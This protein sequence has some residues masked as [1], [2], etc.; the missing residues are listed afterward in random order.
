MSYETFYGLKEPAFSNALDSRFYFESRQHSEALVR[1]LHTVETMKGLT[2]VLG[3]I[4]TG[5]TTLAR[6]ALEMM[7]RDPQYEPS[8][9]V[10]L[11]SDITAEWLLKKIAHHLGVENPADSKDQIVHQLTERILR[12][13]E[14]GR[15]AVV[16]IDE[17]NMIQKKGIFE[18]FRGLLNLEVPGRKLIS[19]VFLGLPELEKNLAL[20]PPLLQRV[21]MKIVLQSLSHG[22][23]QQ[24]IRHRLAVAGRAGDIFTENAFQKI[25][26]YSKGIP[27][28]INTLCDN[29]MLEGYLLKR[30]WIDADIIEQVVLDLGLT[31]SY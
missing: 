19:F 1:M 11:H 14:E 5:K 17:A 6:K 4:G 28:L 15:K 27:R 30:D 18:E 8:L 23:T 21:A 25:F 3:D 12:I 9:L 29:A 24:Y 31:R 26:G 16:V 20:D 7:E 22:S 13:N 2:V 10:I